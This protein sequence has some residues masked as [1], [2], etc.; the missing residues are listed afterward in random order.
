[1]AVATLEMRILVKGYKN[2]QGVTKESIKV[3][4]RVTRS[5]WIWDW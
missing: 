5:H 4:K 3:A 1:L 2:E